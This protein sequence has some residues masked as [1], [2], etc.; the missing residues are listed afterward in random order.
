MKREKDTGRE[1]Q[2]DRELFDEFTRVRSWLAW[3]QGLA[4]VEKAERSVLIDTLAS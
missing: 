1:R 4:V 2:S 3:S